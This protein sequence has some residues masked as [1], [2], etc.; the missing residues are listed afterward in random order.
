VLIAGWTIYGLI[1]LGFAV[2]ETGAQIWL[3]YGVYGL[4]YALTEGASRAFVADLVPEEQ[5]GTAFGIFHAGTGLAL[6][7]ASLLAGVLWQGIGSWSGLGPAAP[8]YFGAFL[9]LF[10]VILFVVWVK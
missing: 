1:Y 4:Y 6:L 9:A 10:A 3:F 2:A 8:F 5:R 7:P